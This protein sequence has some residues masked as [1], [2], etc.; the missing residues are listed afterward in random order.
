MSNTLFPRVL[1]RDF[2]YL[3]SILVFQFHMGSDSVK[4]CC[5][6][7]TSFF[8]ICI[9]DKYSHMSLFRQTCFE[10]VGVSSVTQRWN[11]ISIA[12]AHRICRWHSLTFIYFFLVYLNAW[13]LLN[14]WEISLL[15][16]VFCTLCLLHYSEFFLQ[17]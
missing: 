17:I 6:W 4:Y 8:L 14:I 11:E 5:T 10:K 7:L 16:Q 3:S 13:W 12:Q 15:R 9:K 1:I 2:L